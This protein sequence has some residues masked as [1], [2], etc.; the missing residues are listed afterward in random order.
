MSDPTEASRA[1]DLAGSPHHG[2]RWGS[3]AAMQPSGAMVIAVSLILLASIGYVDWRTGPELHFALFYIFP[4]ALTTWFV[5]RRAGVVM[6]LVSA[7]ARLY[8]ELAGHSVYTRPALAYWNTITRT[9]LFLLAVV[10]LSALKDL[11]LGLEAMV[12][13]RTKAL[14]QLAWQ[15]SETEDLERRRLAHD[16]HD[17]FSQMLSVLKLNLAAALSEAADD[18]PLC[19]RID[20]AILLVNELIQRARTLT[21]DLHP[22]MLEHLGFVPTLRHYGEQFRRQ[23]DIEVTVNEEGSPRQLPPMMANY[24]FRSIKEL[25]N[26]AAK[27]GHA[28]QIVAA[29]HWLPAGLRIVIDDDGAG[30]DP[31]TVLSPKTG[32]GLGLAGISERLR[33]M[34]GEMRVESSPG[35][36]TRAVIEAPLTP[37]EALA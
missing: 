24:L 36:G 14:R 25:V 12:N 5:G 16:I 10:L 32:K 30:F 26:N 15:L 1:T 29:V 21:F 17:G 3:L 2:Y 4:V 20:D 31:D 7:S 8:V 33:S 23:A 34:G 13:D 19:R 37:Q 35:T 11:S 27:H 18:Q 28:R 6:S 9:G 22:A